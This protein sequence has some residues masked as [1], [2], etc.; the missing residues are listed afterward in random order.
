[1]RMGEAG[2][3]GWVFSHPKSANAFMNI[4][5]NGRSFKDGAH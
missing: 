5:N 4:T 2:E 1:M 3:G